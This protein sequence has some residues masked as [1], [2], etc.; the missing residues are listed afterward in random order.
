MKNENKIPGLIGVVIL[1]FLFSILMLICQYLITTTAFASTPASVQ[2]IIIG[3]S[4]LQRI[5]QT[6]GNNPLVQVAISKAQS[7]IIAIAN[8]QISG[9]TQAVNE[10]SYICDLFHKLLS[11]KDLLEIFITLILIITTIIMIY[12]YKHHKNNY[13]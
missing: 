8:S 7:N 4:E 6:Y 12:V 1:I 5:N 3:L 11:I 13:L 9:T 10:L 2:A